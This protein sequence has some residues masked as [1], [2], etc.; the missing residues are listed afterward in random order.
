MNDDFD[1]RDP[2][3]HHQDSAKATNNQHKLK[4]LL[5]IVHGWKRND[6][7]ECLCMMEDSAMNNQRKEKMIR[8]WSTLTF[9]HEIK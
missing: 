7:E 1:Q 2:S 8:Q 9:G 3:Y 4:E 6:W 5:P